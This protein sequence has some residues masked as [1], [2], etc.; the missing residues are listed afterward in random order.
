MDVW[1]ASGD[2]RPPQNVVGADVPTH[3]PPTKLLTMAFDALKGDFMGWGMAGLG[4]MLPVFGVIFL[5]VGVM[6][7]AM[8]P[9][10]LMEDETAASLGLMI[11]FAIYMAILLPVVFIIL[12][13]LQASLTRAI[14][15][16]VIQGTPLTFGASYRTWRENLRDVIVVN[17]LVGAF[18][19]VGLLFCYLPGIV[20]AVALTF[21][22]PLVALRRIRPMDA[23]SMSFN[24]FKTHPGWATKYMLL[25][26][27]MMIIIQ[28][29]PFV[30]AFFALP[31]YTAYLAL[32]VRSAFGE[33]ATPSPEGS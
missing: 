32:G 17:L 22:P 11:G 3:L 13:V 21:A 18:T 19:I 31:F 28:Y 6:F 1:Q 9:G 4:L 5:V 33:V 14:D 25:G 15:E 30:G 8:I 20:V 29:V 7:A 16:R 27:L 23:I 24:H 10:I 12:P 26:I 2:F